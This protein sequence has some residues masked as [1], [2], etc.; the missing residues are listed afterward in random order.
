[1]NAKP[2]HLARGMRSHGTRRRI[3][4][5]EY[6][7]IAGL[8]EGD[9]SSLDFHVSFEGL[10][11][12][13]VI[14]RDIED[15]TDS[16]ARPADGFQLKTAELQNDPVVRTELVEAVEHRF[17][18]V[19]AP[20]HPQ[21]TRTKHLSRERGG[22]RFAVGARDAG[23][24]RAT[25]SEEKVDLTGDLDAPLT[26]GFNQRLVPGHTRAD[27]HK[28]GPV[29][30]LRAV[31]TEAGDDP[32]PLQLRAQF[33]CIGAVDDSDGAAPTP[34]EGGG[35][36]PAATVADDERVS[37]GFDHAPDPG[38]ASARASTAATKEPVQNQS[39]SG[40]SRQPATMKW[41]CSGDIRM[42][43]FPVSLKL[44]TCAIT[45]KV[46]TTK[47]R[48][49]SGRYQR[50]PVAMAAAT[51]AV[52]SARL[53]VSPMNRRAGNR[54]YKRKPTRTP[55]RTAG[56]SPTPGRF[57]STAIN[58]RAPKVTAPVPAA[59]SSLP[60]ARLKAL[61]P[62]A[63]ASAATRM[64]QPPIA[65]RPSNGTSW[66]VR[67]QR[68]A[69]QPS[70]APVRSWT[71][72]FCLAFSPRLRPPRMAE[73]SSKKPSAPPRKSAISTNAPAIERSATR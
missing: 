56:I 46:S 69:S 33:R 30:V 52:P 59:S 38:R 41:L 13:E 44:A 16:K 39:A 23:D 8:H 25:G 31:A 11:P 24:P 10:V 18:D 47:T 40:V 7:V 71:T 55:A 58:A 28:V 12:V 70:K 54:L 63:T 26:C 49:S 21:V 42:I 51:M 20:H 19:A 72:I 14:G 64:I 2:D 36:A 45:E 22:R 68:R 5:V 60:S 43:R 35:G 57:W 1:M 67:P 4:E 27:H 66:F 3:V 34:D 65:C 62:A 53:P 6:G 29:E 9:R 37:T 32:G 15:H 61:E 17:A 73:T 50:K 48:A